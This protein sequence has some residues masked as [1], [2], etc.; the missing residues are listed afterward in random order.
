[1]VFENPGGWA[2]SQFT[3]I[4]FCK[5]TII[6]YTLAEKLLKGK[7]LGKLLTRT[8]AIRADGNPLTLKDSLMR[9]LVRCVPFNALSA[10]G[11]ILWHD[12]WTHTMVVKT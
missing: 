2:Y 4:M 10:L 6:Y 1:M 5:S 7:T 3:Y 11:G 12:S 9:S 8:N